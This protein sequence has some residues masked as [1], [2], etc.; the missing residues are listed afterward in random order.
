MFSLAVITAVALLTAYHGVA[1]AAFRA[2]LG[3]RP[4]ETRIASAQRAFTLEP[5]N[6]SFE[7]RLVR[8]KAE[9]LFLAKDYD[10]AHSL[11][12]PI[13]AAG[14]ADAEFIAFY[15]AV[16]AEWIPWSAGKAHQQHGHEGPGG[17]LRP[18]DVER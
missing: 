8:V 16:N 3:D 10:A 11:M 12:Q 2:A 17:T 1:H 18:E 13:V 9:R 14:D 4:L 7:I 15:R 6:S 5:W